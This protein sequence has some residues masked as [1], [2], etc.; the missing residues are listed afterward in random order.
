VIEVPAIRADGSHWDA[1]YREHGSSGV[2]WYQPTPAVSVELIH[3]LA[4][5]GDAAVLDVGGGA[6]SLA[7][8]LLAEGFC[9]ITVL[10][11]STEGLKA[12]RERLGTNL[13]VDL[14]HADVLEWRPDRSFDLW[15][16]RAVL[17]FLVD[18]GARCRYL[19]KMREAIR[20]G[21]H[22]VIGAFATDGPPSCSGLPVARYSASALAGLLGMDF[23]VVEQRSEAHVTPAGTVQP[24]TW[25]AARLR[26]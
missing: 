3:R 23:D 15:H 22:V 11:I 17:H 1:A 4:I 24:F 6:S 26:E 20:P 7:D 2:S 21:G 16:D 8:A 19:E 12:L 18:K 9:D 13:A 25:V 5:P 14:V 10:D